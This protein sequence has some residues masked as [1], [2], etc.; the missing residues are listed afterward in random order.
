VVDED[1]AVGI[2]SIRD[3]MRWT[4]TAETSAAG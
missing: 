2:V 1:Q 3:V 4:V